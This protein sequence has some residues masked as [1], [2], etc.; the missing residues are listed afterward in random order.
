[1][2]AGLNSVMMGLS[3]SIVSRYSFSSTS[4]MRAPDRLI[5]PVIDGV[6]MLIR[7]VWASTSSRD[8]PAACVI[9][10]GT[11]AS[12]PGAEPLTAP[13]AG[14]SPVP[15]AGACAACSA[16]SASAARRS[17]SIFGLT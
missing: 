9:V 2:A 15:V 8:R 5:D 10:P 13:G 12:L 4:S 7:S 11:A 6:S 17:R 3:G 16:C 1:M 14:V